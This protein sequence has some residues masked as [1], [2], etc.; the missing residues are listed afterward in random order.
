MTYP[1]DGSSENPCRKCGLPMTAEEIEEN[2]NEEPKCR[3]CTAMQQRLQ[4][5]RDHLDDDNYFMP[6][7]CAEVG[8]WKCQLLRSLLAAC[9]HLA[10]NFGIL[11]CG[12]L[13]VFIR[14]HAWAGSVRETHHAPQRELLR[15]DE[16]RPRTEPAQA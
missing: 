11:P 13:V 16:T 12:L 1:F 15:G 6:D 2:T 14:R 8:P 3:K 5:F 7:G 4:D 10:T 9:A